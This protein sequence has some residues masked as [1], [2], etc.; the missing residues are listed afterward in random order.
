MPTASFVAHAIVDSAGSIVILSWPSRLRAVLL[1]R[2]F[3]TPLSCSYD[4]LDG[5]AMACS[6]AATLGKR[7]PM[8][9]RRADMEGRTEKKEGAAQ[10]SRAEQRNGVRESRAVSSCTAQG[11]GRGSRCAVHAA[12]LCARCLVCCSVA[13]HRSLC[14]DNPLQ[15][16]AATLGSTVASSL[17]CSCCC[18]SPSLLGVAGAPLCHPRPRAVPTTVTDVLAA[19]PES[20]RLC[21][22]C[23]VLAP[24]GP[25]HP[26]GLSDLATEERSTASLPTLHPTVACVAPLL[27]LLNGRLVAWILLKRA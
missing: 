10:Q 26:I 13:P 19:A 20:A 9:F 5:L 27:R 2:V 22:R 15:P 23:P 16:L 11:T 24:Q 21:L 1:S 6:T 12:S 14:C 7:E 25:T 18:V 8:V 4:L 17:S 3:L